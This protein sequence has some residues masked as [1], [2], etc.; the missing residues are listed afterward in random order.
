VSA[1]E[2]AAL[3]AL[4]RSLRSVRDF[5]PWPI[6]LEVLDAVLEDANWAPS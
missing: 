3:S 1:A 6:P 2:A 4:I 5:L